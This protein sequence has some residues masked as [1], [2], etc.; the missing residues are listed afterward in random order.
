MPSLND[1]YIY[2]K[3]SNNGQYEP[4]SDSTKTL[5][6]DLIEK[7]GKLTHNLKP[8][9]IE[10]IRVAKLEQEIQLIRQHQR[11]CRDLETTKRMKKTIQYLEQQIENA[12]AVY[13]VCR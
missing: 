13:S 1:E 12:N 4:L 3:W 5:C 10:K 2:S 6:V 9:T 7:A 8:E 11:I